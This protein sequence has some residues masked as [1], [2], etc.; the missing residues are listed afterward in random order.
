M[1]SGRRSSAAVPD[2]ASHSSADLYRFLHVRLSFTP[3][4]R[5]RRALNLISSSSFYIYPSPKS[6]GSKKLIAQVL[7]LPPSTITNR[8]IT[9]FPPNEPRC[10]REVIKEAVAV[11]GEANI[12][13]VEE[14][15][16]DMV[17]REEGMAGEVQ[18]NQRRR[19]F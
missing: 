15:E 12:E 13:E 18:R 4:K 16:E 14:A 5:F 17:G 10:L 3:C 19:I 11:V 7:S 9:F 1:E 6:F 2:F 8:I